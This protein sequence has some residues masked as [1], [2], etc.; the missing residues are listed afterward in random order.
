MS[1][2]LLLANDGERKHPVIQ[3]SLPFVGCDEEADLVAR[4]HFGLV[5]VG[6]IVQAVGQEEAL[7]TVFIGHATQAVLV[8][9]H[10]SLDVRIDKM[11]TTR[12]FNKV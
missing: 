1:H 9:R 12:T 8:A 7:S 5:V 2:D 3:H 11:Y 6:D 10:R 4:L